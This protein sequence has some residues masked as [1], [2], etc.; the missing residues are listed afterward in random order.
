MDLIRVA[1]GLLAAGVLL[2]AGAG[3]VSAQTEKDP[4]YN[5]LIGR[6]LEADNPAGALAALERAAAAD[7]KSAEVQAEIASFHLGRSQRAEAEKAAKAALA[8]DAGNFEANRV[9]GLLYSN[10]AQTDRSASAAQVGAYVRDA[11]TFLERATAIAPTDTNLNFQLGRMY[12]ASGQLEKSIEALTRVV[13]QV[14][15]SAQARR[16]LAQAYAVNDDIYSAIKVL[17]EVADEVEGVRRR[18]GDYQLQA[19]LNMEAAASYAKALDEEPNNGDIK[20]SRIVALYEAG[21]Y[22]QAVAAAA[23]AQ[24]QHPTDQ[25]FPQWQARALSKAGNP[26]RAIEVAETAAKA[27]PRD[28]TTQLVLADVY[29]DAGRGTDAEGVLR[30]ALKAEPTNARVL[31]HLG[32]MLANSG[33]NLDEAIDLVTRALKADPGQGAYMDSLGWAHFRRGDL[34]EAE[35]YLGAAA[36]RMPDSSEVL[37]HLGDL[38]A[39]RGRWREAIAAW[40]RALAGDGSGVDVAVIKKKIADA[41]AK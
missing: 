3:T 39:K 29:S 6:H 31:N 17:A 22:Q 14:P 2:T 11:M 7:P 38:H 21:E 18:L 30:R 9:L 23:D 28:T 20:Q 16:E 24:G 26:A 13:G 41:Q 19:G 37:D 40:T 1:R 25:R 15:F 32:Y 36:E 34:N 10:L 35:K 12:L 27:F 4:Y 5:F 8:L 33:R